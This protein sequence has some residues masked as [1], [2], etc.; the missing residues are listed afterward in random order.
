MPYLIYFPNSQDEKVYELRWGVNTLGRSLGNII[1]LD[2][3]SISRYHAEV[4]W[5]A[6]GVTICDL[7]SSNHTYINEI[8]IEAQVLQD[9]DTIRLGKVIFKYQDYIEQ[10]NRATELEPDEVPTIIK[11][12]AVDSE[13]FGIPE[14]L[15]EKEKTRSILK[16]REQDRQKRRENKLQLLLEVSKELSEPGKL[17]NLLQKILEILLKI[18]Q[19]DR[20][21]ILLVNPKDDRL[22]IKAVEARPGIPTDYQFYSNK[23]MSFVREKQQTIVTADARL[24]RRFNDS[25]SVISQSIH[26]SICAPLKPGDEVIGVLYTDNLSLVNVYSDEDVQFLT[27]LANQAAIAISHSQLY[28]KMETEA[29]LRDK[30]ERF[31]PKAVSSKLREEGNLNKIVETEVTAL[32]SDVSHFTQMSAL[33]SPRE[34][35][36]MLNEYFGTIVEEI[37]FPYEGTLEK[38]IGDALVAVWGSPYRQDD[39]AE[40]AVRAAIAMQWVV[41]RLNIKRQY[42]NQRPIQIHIGLN[43]GEIASGNIGSDRLIQYAHIGDT[44]NVASRI[45][46]AAQADEILI[47]ATTFAQLKPHIIPV[48]RL[49]PITVKGKDEP[50]EIYRVLWEDANPQEHPTSS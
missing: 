42:R 39:D 38:F 22:Q 47:S 6:R 48:E 8:Q 27:A 29:V 24:D 10:D 12:F 49:S 30:L 32:F 44:M 21:A 40:R 28:Q 23:I 25:D 34:V 1:V 35:I 17:E 46:T 50:L 15:S 14:L 11:E 9:G 20:A 41:R 31:F 13:T 18:M 37:V 4:E 7:N 43:T 36:E 19:I 45:C 2:H 16:L 5:N 33:M 26:A 3:A